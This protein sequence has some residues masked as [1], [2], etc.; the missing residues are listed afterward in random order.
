MIKPYKRGTKLKHQFG[1]LQMVMTTAFKS[2]TDATLRLRLLQNIPAS[3]HRLILFRRHFALACFFRHNRYLSQ[4]ADNMIDLKNVALHL[5][6]PQFIISNATDYTNLAAAIGILSIAI[7]RGDPPC[8][9]W[10]T[11]EEKTFNRDID[12]LSLKINAMFAD[13]VDTSASHM[14]RT[15]AKE[16]LEAFQYW[17]SYGVRTK[18]PPKKS[19]FGASTFHGIADRHM[20]EAFVEKGKQNPSL[21]LPD[22][23]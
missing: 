6:D 20:M 10:A 15:E 3:S 4:H 16:V 8:L 21:V 18:P 19:L 11:E 5:E 12:A 2:I 7:D 9:P 22:S 17:L 13:I 14:G 23:V 1:Q